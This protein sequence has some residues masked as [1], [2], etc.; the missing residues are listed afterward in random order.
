MR[1]CTVMR[2]SATNGGWLWMTF[3][4][5]LGSALV[6]CGQDADLRTDRAGP[7]LLLVTLDTTR[8]D[9]LGAY[10]YVA[11]YTPAL[12]GLAARG[13]TFDAAYTPAPMTLPAHATLFTG[14]Q[15]PEHGARVNGEHR[16]AAGIPTLAERL[17]SGGYRT[18]AFVAAFV[19][20]AKFGL[21]RGFEHYDDDRTGAYEQDVSEQLSVYR[22]G[23][24]VVDAAL[25]WLG[26][27]TQTS[28]ASAEHEMPPF[29]A[30]VHFYDPHY[31]WHTHEDLMGTP[32][33]DAETYDAEIAFVDQQVAR[34]LMFLETLAIADETIVAIV[35]DHGEGLGDHYETEHGYLLNEEVLR[36]P[37]I[38]AGPGVGMGQRVGAMVALVDFLP[39]AL[40][41]LGLDALPGLRGRS[42]APAL[43]GELIDSRASYAETDLPW[44]SFRWSPQ[45]SLTTERWKYVRTAQPELYD[46]DA[47]RVELANLA[48]VR[49]EKLAELDAQL[50]ELE[51]GLAVRESAPAA[52]DADERALLASLGYVTGAGEGA[53]E[54]LLADVKERLVTKDLSA[55]LRR[56]LAAKSLSPEEALEI[57]QTL[58]EQSPETPSFHG[59]L[60]AALVNVG[61]IERGLAELGEAVR[62]EPTSASAHY[63]LGDVLEQQGRREE[64]RAHFET[65]LEIDPEFAP[66]HVGM[67]NV[68][69]AEGHPDL[70]AGQYTE[71]IRLRPGYAEA[72]YNLAQ[73]FAQRGH[74]EPAI[75]QFEEAI[76]NRSEWALP[77]YTLANLLREQGQNAPAIA[78]YKTV[79][80]LDP[81]DVDAHNNLG[82][83][84]AA[85]GQNAEAK[86][87]YKQ[88]LRLAPGFFRPYLNLGDMAA[89]AGDYADAIRHY[90]QALELQA[91]AA[92]PAP[93]LRLARLLA[94]CPD[95]R[96]RDGA[97]A[98]AL[99]ERA[100]ARVEQPDAWLLDTLAAAYAAEGRFADAESTAGRA[101]QRAG[102]DGQTA[103]ADEIETRRAFYARGEPYQGFFRTREQAVFAEREPA[104]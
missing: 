75:E 45:R 39:T 102:L 74:I 83:T 68:L 35:A 27:L 29:F 9:R 25:A 67:G 4:A 92:G 36:V 20:D 76:R 23:N 88:A 3:V 79:L 38:V 93:A 44:T 61:E 47:D 96:L 12:D 85:A 63:D 100:A 89:D 73:T 86:D 2:G 5:T 31:P 30:W 14:L 91:N 99:A 32:L 33:E 55:W 65:A 13:T 6:V 57:A 51:A 77:H 94:T 82:V 87:H 42:L 101:Q 62:L 22:P 78:H 24:L 10:G 8:A 98:T 26:G 34:L 72:H 90:E 97:R 54:G 52:L 84:F 59:H 104:H 66:A 41:L 48:E 11:A 19:L 17:A 95:S 81:N 64:A 40:D 71:A 37:W 43:R 21:D 70:A 60:G 80:E 7:N 15:P 58:V 69:L 18:G 53:P 50:A 56:G 103:L 1:G 16:L 49:A 46:R 28:D